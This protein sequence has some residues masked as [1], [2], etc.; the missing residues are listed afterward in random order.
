[1]G[2]LYF[3]AVYFME[4]HQLKFETYCYANIIVENIGSDLAVWEFVL[5]KAKI[6][7]SIFLASKLFHF[8]VI[9]KNFLFL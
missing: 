2:L 6:F 7:A 3:K 9:M 1:M 4:K 8:T 5:Q